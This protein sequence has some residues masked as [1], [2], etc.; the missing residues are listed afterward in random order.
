MKFP[1]LHGKIPLKPSYAD[2]TSQVLRFCDDK[3]TIKNICKD[4]QSMVKTFS[5]QGFDKEKLSGHYKLFCKKYLYKWS[6]YGNDIVGLVLLL[7]C[8]LHRILSS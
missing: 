8:S 3:G 5:Q 2:F 6:K 4:V 1:H 7:Y